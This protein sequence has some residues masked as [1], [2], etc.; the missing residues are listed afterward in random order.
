MGQSLTKA[1]VNPTLEDLGENLRYNDANAFIYLNIGTDTKGNLNNISIV[2]L[3]PK[4][5]A[6][7]SSAF[8]FNLSIMSGC[9]FVL[10]IYTD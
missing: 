5:D 7:S 1:P 2:E 4:S 8:V 9:I 3:K 10:I 6:P